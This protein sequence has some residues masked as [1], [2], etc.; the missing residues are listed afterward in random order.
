MEAI[1]FLSFYLMQIIVVA[2]VGVTLA[3]G[4][5]QLVREKTRQIV[6]TSKTAERPANR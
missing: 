6:K 1:K 2:L 3:A 4:I 5:Y